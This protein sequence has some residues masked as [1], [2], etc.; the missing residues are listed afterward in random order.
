MAPTGLTAT[1]GHGRITLNWSKVSGAESYTV[2]RATKSD[3]PYSTV[4]S[5]LRAP[6]FTDKGLKN[7]KD[8]YYVVTSVNRLGVS[9]NSVQVKATPSKERGTP[10]TGIDN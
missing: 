5:N 8:Y 1:A 6:S 4:V 3:G 2:K 9:P 10:K 7:G